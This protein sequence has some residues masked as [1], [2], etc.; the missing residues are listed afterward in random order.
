MDVTTIVTIEKT[1]PGS[2]KGFKKGIINSRVAGYLKI[3]V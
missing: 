2:G 3:T 1:L